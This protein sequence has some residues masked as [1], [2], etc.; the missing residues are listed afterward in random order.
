VSAPRRVRHPSVR[1]Y[2]APVADEHVFTV[3]GATAVPAE[4][5]TLAEAG[6]T[7][8][9]HLQEWVVAHPSMLGSDVMIVTMEF[10]RWRSSTGTPERDR[11]DVLGLDRNGR[12]VVAEL[13]RDVAP[14]TVEMQALKYAA[15]VSRFTPE[16]LATQHARYLTRR[17]EPTDDGAARDL[18][19]A[20]S[21]FGLVPE[22]L[23]K[24]RIVLLASSF[25]PVVTA[26]TVWLTEMSLD[27]TLMRFQAYRAEGQVLVTASQL[28][29]VP[30]VE[31]FTVAPARAAS[32]A[33]AG[34][35]N[36]PEVPW[37][38][39]DL[40]RLRSMASSTVLAALDLCAARPSGWIPLREIEER[41]GR[42]HA[43]ARADLAV[44][45]MTVK[46][47]FGRS[48]WPFAAQ[49]AAGGERQFYYGVTPEL[50]ALWTDLTRAAEENATVAAGAAGAPSA[51]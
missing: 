45:T 10:D 41:A 12:L 18:L 43:Q 42:E 9:S 31:D 28:Y 50:A 27:I 33:G 11:L 38:A 47:H 4:P 40:E 20:H 34:A 6:F 5:I 37:T 44:L 2:D 51:T 14:D 35:A 48:N 16:G 23:A 13:K 15:M 24:P 46:R 22:N 30:D 25:P 29:P 21:E 7:E 39:D 1:K 8:R 32:T 36:F 19:E 3:D 49:W 17:G 26:T